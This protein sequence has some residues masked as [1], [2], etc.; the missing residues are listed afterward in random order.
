MGTGFLEIVATTASGAL[1]VTQARVTVSSGESVL[2]ELVTDESG[3]TEAVPLEA[4]TREHSLNVNYEGVPYSVCDVKVE[5]VGFAT[6]IIYGVKILDTETSILP[7]NLL[8]ALEDKQM[9]ELDI[10][11]HNLVSGEERSMER[12]DAYALPNGSDGYILNDVIIPEFI[13]VHL[14][15]PDNPLARNVRVPFTHYI[16]NSASHEIFATWPPAALEANIYCII[17]LT[18]NRLYHGWYRVRGYNFDITNSTQHDQM[19]VEGGQIFRTIDEMVDRIFNRF[20][21]RE[22]SPF[23]AE[24]CDGRHVTCSGL[25]QWG[26]VPLA[27]QGRNALQILHHFYP[28]D[29]QIVETNNIGGEIEP[30]MGFALRPGMNLPAVY[31]IQNRLNTISKNFPAISSITNPSG[32]YDT[33]TE[34]AVRAFQNVRESGLIASNGIV[35]HTTWHRIFSN[36][37]AVKRL[38]GLVDKRTSNGI[39]RIPF[40]DIIREGMNGNLVG[41]AQHILN[42]ISEFYPSV[43]SLIENFSFTQD[44]TIAIREFQRLFGLSQDGIIGP[45]TWRMLNNVYWR[46]YD[47]VDI[48]SIPS[49]SSIPPI[50]NT[51]NIPIN[52][53][54]PYRDTDSNEADFFPSGEIVQEECPFGGVCMNDC[55][56]DTPPPCSHVTE[57]P[58][59]VAT[60][61]AHAPKNNMNTLFMCM[62]LCRSM[63]R[64]KQY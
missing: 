59:P 25:W 38:D 14:G 54:E 37:S 17:S 21:R 46:I 10:P 26:T 61:N 5:A 15:Y 44:M 6:T 45:N 8:P 20:I 1:P 11:A 63:K 4:P 2:Y 48:P 64:R 49:I 16:K 23:F 22:N 30:F 60:S 43:P 51:P 55:D 53:Q 41:R 19:F 40:T 27:E 56:D 50:P 42:F 36:Y 52:E 12:P 7:I 24:Y 18:L 3:I 32:I 31:T 39:E 35:E 57:L 13:T 33:Q 28:T 34:V 58:N 9:I 47:T 29:I 62:F